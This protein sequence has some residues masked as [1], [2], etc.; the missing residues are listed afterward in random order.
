MH[1]SLQEHFLKGDEISGYKCGGCKKESDV[2][3]RTLLSKSPNV[4]IVMLKRFLF[5]FD[6]FMTD[7]TNSY[8]EFPEQLDLTPYSFYN[9]MKREG[10][11]PQDAEET[12]EKPVEEENDEDLQEEN[13]EEEKKE[14]QEA[15]K[16]GEDSEPEVLPEEEDCF[17]YKL[18][19][20]VTHSG[21][22]NSGHYWS[23]IN[24]LRGV[25]EPDENDP[26]WANTAQ[27]KWMEFNDSTVRDFNFDRLK[28]E[29]FGGETK[30]FSSSLWGFGGS[31]SYGQSGYTLF[32]EKRKKNP[33]KIVVPK[34][35]VETEKSQ[36]TE[37]HEDEK[38]EEH[39]KLIDYRDMVDDVQPNK[40]YTEVFEQNK[41]LEFENEIYSDEF[42]D[43]VTSIMRNVR[44]IDTNEEIDM[45]IRKD[46]Q[47][48]ADK[49]IYE[50]LAKA[51]KNEC[52]TE[53]A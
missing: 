2:Q 18:V 31:T 35:Q 3:K 45:S 16:D 29:T 33:I 40:L 19:G 1:E 52:I 53:Y 14:D 42:F 38:N 15:K 50:I 48:I 34:E 12:K 11:L 5:N 21:S 23:Y 51:Y 30:S 4:L 8:F 44:H 6:T 36:G 9:V 24:T 25:D 39:Y 32:Y 41:K 22:A 10:K 27:D 13:K 7:K 46:T 49:M 47:F 43:F 17:E 26:N 37:V 28:D 20:V